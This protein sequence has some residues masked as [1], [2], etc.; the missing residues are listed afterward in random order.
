MK[1]IYYFFEL[2]KTIYIDK[3][4]D[5]IDIEKFGEEYQKLKDENKIK[6]KE[7]WKLRYQNVNSILTQGIL[8]KE[9]W[10][11]INKI[12]LQNKK[13][14][15]WRE[16]SNI[17]RITEDFKKLYRHSDNNRNW[18]HNEIAK[19]IQ[20]IFYIIQANSNIYDEEQKLYSPNS[21]AI[22]Y[23]GFSQKIIINSILDQDI[24]KEISNYMELFKKIEKGFDLFLHNKIRT[25]LFK[26]KEDADEQKNLRRISIIPAWLMVLEKLTKPIIQKLINKKLNKNQFGFRPKSD[27]GL[28]KAMIFFNAKKYKYNKSL[29]IDIKKAFDSVNLD[30]LIQIVNEL[31]KNNADNIII[32]SFIKIYQKLTLIINNTEINPNRG[33]PQGSA[34]SPILFSLYINN[35]L[36]KLNE[37]NEIHLQ[38]YADDIII[39]GKDLQKIQ[40]YY[41]KAKEMVKELDFKMEF[42]QII[43]NQLILVM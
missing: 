6:N 43:L 17:N 23:N 35:I 42:L 9:N 15:I 27:C 13:S 39:Q 20:T 34:L 8:S 14:K 37:K 18:D 24:N 41:N 31:F 10:I 32:N 11:K 40:E 29:L 36:N 4:E 16:T 38:A 5:K 33:L 19:T 21:K 28:A 12:I 26:K 25:I 3:I 7:E 22:D 2:H 1:I 30:K